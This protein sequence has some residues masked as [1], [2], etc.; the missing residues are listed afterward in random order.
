[1]RLP[2]GPIEVEIAASFAHLFKLLLRHEVDTGA[3]RGVIMLLWRFA[4]LIRGR[5]REMVL[6]SISKT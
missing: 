5:R 3:V 1:M 6:I 4:T 2:T